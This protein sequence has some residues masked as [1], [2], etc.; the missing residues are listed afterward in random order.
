M[1]VPIPAKDAQ[2]T[3]QVRVTDFGALPDDGRDDTPAILAAV[4][5]CRKLDKATLVFPKGRYDFFAG[6]NPNDSNHAIVLDH[7]A[8]LTIDG[9]GTTLV[10]HGV[11]GCFLM[12]SCQGLAIQ[13][14]AID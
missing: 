3:Q 10:F 7:L 11:T 1:Q 14:L 12:K 4:A 2:P 9:Q 6:A 13:N 5:S 8:N